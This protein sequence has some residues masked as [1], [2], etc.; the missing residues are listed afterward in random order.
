MAE[1]RVSVRLVAEGGR[2]V[3]AELEGI[4]GA[5]TRGF[6]RLSS[7]MELAN[8]RLGSFARKAGI[9]LAAVTAAAAAAGVAMVRSGLEVI[10]A[11]ADMAASLKTT[12]ESLQ[13]LTWAGELAGVSMGE[14]EQAT[15]KLT[16]RLSEAAAG[17]GSAV[18]ALERLNLTAAE[19]QALP[20]DQRIVAIQ[21][22][23]NRFVPEAERA[24]V[25]SD[26]F[27]DK[28]ALAFLRIDP[29][30]LREAAQDVRD[31]GVAVSAA[32]ADQIER[33]GDAIAK[34][35]LIWLGLTNRL[36]AAVAPALETV[37]NALAD[38][39]RG[40]GP[41][42]GAISMVFDNLA[43]L[44]TYAATFAAF[45]AGR[46][47]A[48][49]AVAALS[50]RGLA[51]AL[52]IMRGALIR[53]GIGALI[54]GAGELV[55]Q[56]SQ[57]VTR[58]GGVGEAFRLLGDLASE[59]WSRI[60]LALDAAFANMAAGWEG[61]N[62]AG[63]SAL[64]ST[65][66]GVVSFGDRTA[67]IFQGAYDAAVAIWSSLPGAIG[68][69]A[70]Q[71][72]NGLISGVE[73]MLNGVVTRINNFINGL[74]AALDL[75]PDWAVGEGG[76]RVGTLDPV[77]LARIGNP[78]EGAATAAGAAAADAFSAALSRTYLEPPDLGLGAMA[79]DA[80]G[81]AD[82]YREAAGM[83]ADAAGRPLASWQA[84]R[85]AVTGTGTE[86]EAALADAASSADAL[87]A[88]LDGT[89]AAAG[90]AG[91]A[92]R[93]AGAEAAAGADRAATGWGAV[94]AALADYA[95]KA[96]DIGGDIG[97]ALVGA[98]TSAENAVGEFVK[99]G[100]LDFRDLVTSMIADLAKLA[101]R[102][103]ILGPI[104]NAL[105]GALGGAGGIFANILHAGGMVGSPGPGRMVPALA[106]AGA[107]RMHSGG[108]AGIKPDEVPAI[109]QKGERVL[110]R[111][112]A[113][114]YGQSSAPAVNV[115]IMA[116]DAESFRQSRTQVAS[117]IARAVSLGRRGM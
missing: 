44:A 112:E 15:K 97:Q 36:T 83:L 21:E 72:A 9:A 109:L 65:I 16:T 8:A 32:D 114:G 64:E 75:L 96:R 98:F 110:S 25:A 95:A 91:A 115:T 31:F 35:S 33:T 73:A 28:A 17:S 53:T 6:G 90:S 38:M 2:Q 26:L 82:G 43:R 108:W 19:L 54:V 93:E 4:G 40:T 12:V 92:A 47:V 48:G 1:K 106:F 87:N 66:A 59:V 3:R 100:K 22:A 46:W 70:F 71:A 79:A 55:Y 51:T 111:R 89:A 85:D 50:V 49:L 78:F 105:S 117:D 77:E 81:R 104:A 34:L 57:L 84:L 41:I 116:R 27:G 86:A 18:G 102:T 7:E 88:E 107:P 29:A 61:L 23:L 39:A 60:G 52:V 103:F 94:T 13:V 99:T 20:L 101:A 62:A 113:A 10:G 69:F 76:V 14:I 74:N 30:T 58:V 5:G 68:D 45:M 80:R 63:L 67:A 11:Q 56:L 42:G 37:A 24:A